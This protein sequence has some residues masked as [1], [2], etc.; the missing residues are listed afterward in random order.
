VIQREGFR[1]G[2]VYRADGWMEVV[3]Q[4]VEVRRIWKRHDR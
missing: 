4:N 2:E 3:D 1:S